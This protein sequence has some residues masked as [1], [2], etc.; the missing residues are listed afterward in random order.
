MQYLGGFARL[1]GGIEECVVPIHPLGV[2][3]V[4]ETYE[5]AYTE[6]EVRI[7]STTYFCN[8]VAPPVKLLLGGK[9][10]RS[11]LN[12]LVNKLL[13]RRR[14]IEPSPALLPVRLRAIW[15]NLTGLRPKPLQLGSHLS[16]ASS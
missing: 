4:Y 12:L 6:V 8:L 14:I 9:N 11:R 5:L 7:G 13:I 10:C 15:R 1:E 2:V 16:R 3:R